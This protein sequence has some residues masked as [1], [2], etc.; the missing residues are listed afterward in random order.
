MSY[1]NKILNN[2]KQATL[3]IEK[4]QFKKLSLRE[5]IE[6]HIHLAGCRFCRLYNKQSNMINDMIQQLYREPLKND[7]KLDD[8]FKAGLKARIEAGLKQ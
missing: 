7:L 6:L 2:C 5:G 4:K 1:L 8:A 3:L